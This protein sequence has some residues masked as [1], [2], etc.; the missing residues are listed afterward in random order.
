MNANARLQQTGSEVYLSYHRDG[1]LDIFIGSGLLLFGLTVFSDLAWMGGVIA[2]VLAPLW[3]SVK[4]GITAPR[5]RTLEL[6]P[7]QHVGLRRTRWRLTMLGVV[8]FLLG[9]LVFWLVASDSM[10][11]WLLS[12]P[13]VLFGG[14]FAVGLVAIAAVGRLARYYVYAGLTLAV[15]I[16][17]R[18]LNV[19]LPFAITLA[20]ITIFLAGLGLLVRFVRTHPRTA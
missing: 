13:D 4:K 5:V 6:T 8:A 14:A 11:A 20:G 2:A 10:P 1:L 17:A 16:G 3:L 7:A 15:F 19:D 18:L 9:A 12:R